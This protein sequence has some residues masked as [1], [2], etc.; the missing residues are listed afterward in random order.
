MSP[1]GAPAP[2]AKSMRFFLFGTT[3]EIKSDQT[4]IASTLALNEE[5]VMGG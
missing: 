2:R 1:S 4:G 3:L 5:V